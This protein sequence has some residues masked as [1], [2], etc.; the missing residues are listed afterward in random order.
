[1]VLGYPIFSGQSSVDQLV[2]II[3]ILGIIIQIQRVKF[4]YIN[5]SVCKLMQ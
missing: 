2:R 1:M 4:E 3:Q 5:I